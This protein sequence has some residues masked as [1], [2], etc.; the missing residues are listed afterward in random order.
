[1]MK[2]AIAALA[3]FLAGHALAGTI[4]IAPGADAGA[5]LQEALILAAPGDVIELAAGRYDLVEG[6]S[7]DVDDVSVKGA[8]MDRTVL[9]FA[10]Q[11]SGAE[12]LLVT[13]DR[14]T[15][16]DF[17]IEDTKGDGIKAKG[18]KEISF[19]N[20]R[21][22]WTGG[23]RE[24]N[25]AYG[26]Y[27]VESEDV[28][29]EGTHVIGASDA[30]IYVGQSERI[31]VRNSVAERNVA[32]IEI[33]NSFLADVHGNRAVHNS[34]GILVFDL[35]DLPRQGG[36]GVR[37]F[38]NIVADNMTENFAPKG[39][40]VASVP[41]GTG[42]MIMANR[43]VEVFANRFSGNGTADVLVIAYPFDHEDENY[44]PY[45]YGISL[46][47]NG[48]SD[49]AFDP[50]ASGV[51]EVLTKR[52]AG[53]GAHI[54][55]DGVAPLGRLIFGMS[56]ADRLMIDEPEGTRF[57]NLRMVADAL[58]PWRAGISRDI[59]AHKGRHPPLPPVRLPQDMR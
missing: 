34:G 8:G 7:L 28:L 44:R 2:T 36:H 25:G 11:I 23:P 47:D 27:P 13:S 30:G 37:V 22:E 48:Y 10:G 51:G 41:R 43:D 31:V 18:V 58:L 17:A 4:K 57:A 35:P 45:P 29:I 33:E 19:R 42:L 5:R 12:G 55:W 32:G 9:S 52:L 15:L 1:M 56:R 21:V 39:N 14:V 49:L 24:T 6:L 59:S 26:L 16:A 20:I 40:I 3:F 54:V 38:D 50:P 53:E 46:H